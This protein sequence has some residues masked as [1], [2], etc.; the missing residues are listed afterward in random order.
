M[1]AAAQEDLWQ[2]GRDALPVDSSL[3][4]RSDE[5]HRASRRPSHLLGHAAEHEPGEP[6]GP[7]RADDDEL[8]ADRVGF[9]HDRCG[10]GVSHDFALG[11]DSEAPNGLHQRESER[12][13]VAVCEGDPRCRLID[14]VGGLE[15]RATSTSQWA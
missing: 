3:S 14:D 9:F 12:F 13:V 11:V 10:R 15:A 8:R 2:A 7:M 5:Q 4:G 6:R 1:T